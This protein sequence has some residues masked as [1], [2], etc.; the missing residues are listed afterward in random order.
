[1]TMAA[2][3]GSCGF[4]GARPESTAADAPRLARGAPLL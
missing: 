4:G 2:G 3:D 1:M